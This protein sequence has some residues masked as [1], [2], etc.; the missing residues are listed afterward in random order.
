M[1]MEN[2]DIM[3]F[4]R[5]RLSDNWGV[6]VATF[7]VYLV[8]TFGLG[9]IPVI[10][11]IGGFIIAGPLLVGLHRF[12]LAIA[13]NK[14]T[15]TG[16]LFDAF[17]FFANGLVAYILVVVFTCLW[18]LLLVVPGIMAAMSYSMT[19]FILA[20]NMQLDGQEAIRRSK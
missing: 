5:N 15:R 20:D 16:Q 14:E 18:T 7:L 19:F 6:P 3:T 8:I 10:G 12:S 9:S 11:W 1:A 4:A 13:R 17:P 2:R